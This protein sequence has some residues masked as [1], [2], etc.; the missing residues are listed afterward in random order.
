MGTG[1]E[2][3]NRLHIE[4]TLEEYFFFHSIRYLTFFLDTIRY[5][6]NVLAS[7]KAFFFLG[8]FGKFWEFSAKKDKLNHNFSVSTILVIGH[9]I[10][11]TLRYC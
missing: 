7:E 10:L 9:S 4:D 6:Y 8:I 11:D 1:L 3:K 2:I 5:Q